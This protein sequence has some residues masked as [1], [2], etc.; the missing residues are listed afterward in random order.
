MIFRFVGRF[1]IATLVALHLCVAGAAD[2]LPATKLPIP[3]AGAACGTNPN[4]TVPFATS[5]QASTAV[6]G[7]TL[8]VN[9]LSNKAILN[10][11]DFNIGK[12]GSVIFKQPGV[13]SSA[14]NR[15]WQA[16]P[17]VI[18]GALKANGQIFLI[19]QNGI[20]FDKGAQVN[21]GSL[22]A[23][24]LNITDELFQQGFLSAI[25]DTSPV[26]AFDAVT[27]PDGT[28]LSGSIVV[29]DGATL[30]ADQS[31]NGRIMLFGTNVQNGG[32]ITAPDGQVVLAAGEKVYLLASQD[33]NLRGLF[34]EVANP[35]LSAPNAA[36]D[37]AGTASNL[38]LGKIIAERGNV[39]LAGLAVNQNG[40]ISATTA[41]NANGSIRLQA[42][43]APIGVEVESSVPQ[44]FSGRQ[45]GG[46]LALGK[47]SMSEVLPDLA[48][49]A[50][51]DSNAVFN[52]SAVTLAGKSILHQGKILAPGG[53]V[54]LT[55]EDASGAP[56]RVFLAEGSSIDVAGTVSTLL[57]M[58]RNQL[59]VELRGDELKDFPVQRDGFLR[60]QKVTIDVSRGTTVAD[61]SKQVAAIQRG[62]GEKSAQGGNI[63]LSS[64]NEVLIQPGAILDVSGGEVT[65]QSGFLNT[66]KLVD[67]DGRIFD[68]ASASPLRTY[69]GLA[70]T[71]VDEHPVWR[72]NRSFGA[73][74]TSQFIPSFVE[75]QNA[76]QISVSGKVL[77]LEGLMRGTATAGVN[78][79]E[80][81]KRPLAGKLAVGTVSPN[82]GSPSMIDLAV[83]KPLSPLSFDTPP[84]NDGALVLTVDQMLGGGL[85]RFAFFADGPI[86]IPGDV[87]LNLS[88]GGELAFTGRG[89]ELQGSIVAPSGS[90]SL[91]SEERGGASGDLR[92]GSSSLLSARGQWVND[93]PLLQLQP[94][95][96]PALINGGS[97]NLRSTANLLIGDVDGNGVVR[98]AV[99]DVS[100]G[101]WLTDK[102]QLRKGNGGSVALEVLQTLDVTKDPGTLQLAAVIRALAPGKG[103]RLSISA[104]EVLLRNGAP[105]TGAQGSYLAP[106][107]IA[108][109]TQFVAPSWM[110][111]SLGFSSYELTDTRRGLSIADD[112]QINLAAP[113][114]LL[115]STFT[116]RETGSD[117]YSFSSEASDAQVRTPTNLGLRHNFVARPDAVD[118]T[119]RV[120]S[121]SSI[122][123]DP[124]ANVSITSSTAI[125]ADGTIRAPAGNISLTLPE[126]PTALYG[127]NPRG[128][129]W[130]G[131]NASLSA[132]G[133]FVPGASALGLREGQVL[134]G[135][136][137]SLAANEGYIVMAPGSR[138][139]V[140]GASAQIDVPR[141][142]SSPL[143][144][145]SNAGSVTLVAEQGMVLGGELRAR[146]GTDQAVGGSLTA[147]VTD[148]VRDRSGNPDLL[149]QFPTGDRSIR[150]AQQTAAFPAEFEFGGDIDLKAENGIATFSVEQTSLGAFAS[151]VLRADN[152]VQLAEG[153]A[154]KQARS[155]QLD[156]PNLDVPGGGATLSAPY[157]ALGHSVS[158]R[159]DAQIFQLTP[160]AS[161]GIGSLSVQADVID[162]LGYIGL[163]GVGDTLLAASQAIRT[164]GVRS[165][166]LDPALA[167]ETGQDILSGALL[168]AGNITL[169]SP[170]TYPTSASSYR[171]KT[172]TG[173]ITI[174]S[175]SSTNGH[176]GILSAGG[177]LSVE[178]PTIL[179]SGVLRAPLG[180]IK[181]VAGASL[182]LAPGSVTSTAMTPAV[183]AVPYG[184]TQN[185]L[186]WLLDLGG[187]SRPLPAPPQASITLNAPQ[188]DIQAG[189]V[190]D[191]SGGGDLYAYEFVSG[192][193]GS[194]DTLAAVGQQ[195]AVLPALGAGYAPYDPHY[196][197]G[198]TV[199]P[200]DA[201][202]ISGAGGLPSGTYTM[203]PARYA[204]L[205]GAYLVTP[206]SGFQDLQPGDVVR[207]LD[208]V[209]IVAG[210]RA[211]LGTD[212]VDSRYSG[213]TVEPGTAARM[214]SE[215]RDSFANAFFATQALRRDTQVPRLPRDAGSLSA[216]ATQSLGFAGDFL[217]TPAKDGRGAVVDVSAQNLK[218]VST[219]T[220][221]PSFVQL[222]V[223]D[224]SNLKAESLLIGGTRSRSDA[225]TQ[226]AI[227]TQQ[228]VVDTAGNALSAPEIM[229]AATDTITVKSGSVVDG[230]G[231]LA[232]DA[233]LS[234]VD[235]SGGTAGALV[236]VSAAALPVALQRPANVDRTRG[237]IVIDSGAELRAARSVLLDAS[238]DTRA[239]GTISLGQGGELSVGAGRISLG[240]VG[241]VADGLI[242]NNDQL[243]GLTGLRSLNLRSYSS[244]DFWGTAQLAGRAVTLDAAALLGLDN[245]GKAATVTAD[246]LR[247]QNSNASL[248][249]S[250][251]GG[252]GA[253][254]VSADQLVLGAGAKTIRGFA[255]SDFTG[256]SE[257]LLE[258][259]GALN[260]DGALKLAAHRIA[261][262]SAAV[263]EVRSAGALEIAGLARPEDFVATQ[264]LGAHLSFAGAS[265]L[266]GG[267]IDA[268]AG[269]VELRAEGANGSLR[270]A[271]GSVTSAPGAT[272]NF[273]GLVLPLPAGKVRLVSAQGDVE[274]QQGALVDVSARGEAGAAGSISVSAIGGNALLAG[275]LLATAQSPELSGSFSLDAKSIGATSAGPQDLGDLISLLNLGQFDL[276]RTFRVRAGDLTLPAGEGREMRARSVRVVADAGRIDIQGVIRANAPKGGAIEIAARDQIKLHAGAV[277]DASAA[278]ALDRAGRISLATTSGDLALDSGS[279]VALGSSVAPGELWLRAPRTRSIGAALDNEVAVSNIAADL[280]GAGRVVVEGFR[281]YN[282]VDATDLATWQ[283]DTD[284]YMQNANTIQARLA[285]GA[286]PVVLRPGVEIRSNNDFALGSSWDLSTWRY[287]GQP[288]ALT[289]R[290]AGNLDLGVPTPP[291][292]QNVRAAFQ[293]ILNDGFDSSAAN[294]QLL[295]NESWS[296]RL[297]AGADLASAD[298]LALLPL[299]QLSESAGNVTLAASSVVRTGTGSIDIAAGRDF[300]LGRSAGGVNQSSAAVYTAGR[301]TTNND[302]PVL[303][304]DP[305][306]PADDFRVPTNANYPT[307]GGNV[308]IRAQQ[309]VQ[310]AISHQ[311]ITNWLQRRGRTNAQTGDILT[312]FNTSWHI[313]F[314]RFQ[315]NVGA[316]GGGNVNVEAGRDVIN[317]S[318]VAPTTGRLGGT[319]EPQ[320]DGSVRM[321]VLPE[322]LVVLG[323]GDIRIDAARDI[324]SG[325]FFVARGQANLTAGGS[326]R[327]GRT[328]A[329]TGG[330]SDSPIHTIL[331]LADGDF[332]LHAA[333]DIKLETVLNPTAIPQASTGTQPL[334]PNERTYFFTYSDQAAVSATALTGGV[335][336]NNDVP[337]LIDSALPR[338]FGNTGR[339][340]IRASSEEERS[341]T[342]YAPT[343]AA[344]AIEGTITQRLGETYLFPAA[345]GNLS[346]LAG[347]NVDLAAPGVAIKMLDV[348]LGLLPSPLS[349]PTAGVPTFNPIAA[350]LT[351]LGPQSHADPLLHSGDSQLNRI[352]ALEGD[353]AGAFMLPK[354]TRFKAGRDITNI[355]FVGQ[356]LEAS[357]V[358]ALNAGRDVVFP[359]VRDASGAISASGEIRLGGPGRLELTAGRNVDLGSA[360][361]V[362]TQGRRDNQAL[363]EEGASITIA[364]GLSEVTDYTAFIRKFIDP[365]AQLGPNDYQDAKK[366]AAASR[367]ILKVA[368]EDPVE[369]QRIAGLSDEDALQSLRTSWLAASG[370]RVLSYMRRLTG[371]ETLAEAQALEQ[372]KGL[373]PDQ[374]RPVVLDVFYDQL[375][376]GGRGF[377]KVGESA[378]A[379]GFDAV[380]TLFPGSAYQGDVTLLLSQIKTQAGGDINLLVPGGKVNA[381]QT[382]A[383]GEFGGGKSAANLGL[384]VEDTGNIRSFTD[385]NFDVNESRVVTL[386]GG[387][388]LMWSSRGDIDAGRGA[389]T[390]AAAPAPVLLIDNN[391]GTTFRVTAFSGSGIRSFLLE[392]G[393][394]P[395]DVDLIAPTGEVNAG[396][397]GIGAA[398]N[399]NIAALRVVG[400]DNIQVGGLSTGVPISDV[401]GIGAG[402]TGLSNVASEASKAAEQ[403]TQ[404]AV[405]TSGQADAL[406]KTVMPSFITVE[407]LDDDADE[408]ERK[409]RRAAPK[410]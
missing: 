367:E 74:S 304:G 313:D 102:G 301:A 306:D 294:A 260:V 63:T 93:S 198:S 205:P 41:V 239:L 162:L 264:G 70:G 259:R 275:N 185:G 130:L 327:E 315:Q 363:P 247:F 88:P 321:R 110:F 58:S 386:R 398:G 144:V 404:Q 227:G 69:V 361:G 36:S 65:Y 82:I 115:D 399:L 369:Q 68:I 199:R 211:V 94:G 379:R 53:K 156:A 242:L 172:D 285:T 149:S 324:A 134:P 297:V 57:P 18:Q 186:E 20:L 116:S 201:I 125:F 50:T 161:P 47:D 160:V 282:A 226:I 106:A 179:Q 341:F 122:T 406:S 390:A 213:F 152:S 3:C 286:T 26:S 89:I 397:A 393:I 56:T 37:S 24:T 238:S 344:Y 373:A 19:N 232:A 368:T 364:A 354:A 43:D 234:L 342:T 131:A 34:V 129:I 280:R 83:S 103:G 22:V 55:A 10:W 197:F 252:T 349:I 60:G 9:Q 104:G 77:R 98:P 351:S 146:A 300:V 329:D 139:D 191:L 250:T 158:A 73:D 330:N 127:Y 302:F 372:F 353:I 12:D 400:A 14:L 90:I 249:L 243:A 159:E 72:T 86:N 208:G 128:A 64:V 165:P 289:L 207:R 142:A 290:A 220:E 244:I 42:G 268:P 332:K 374:Q 331:A 119:V 358:T 168:A 246:Q 181:L 320:P 141:Q 16:D 305:N 54:E 230:T 254:V 81:G 403:A 78:Q 269:V 263:N 105:V 274:L 224:L 120:G 99:L 322:N 296:Y 202:Q 271:A 95:S 270:L 46:A 59:E 253:L 378:Y 339:D 381:G 333:G 138:I 192:P 318:V 75:G 380:N 347:E 383:T 343:L 155:L 11:Q 15:I 48:S 216:F 319:A 170:Q 4:L 133:V 44:R 175:A 323:G 210:R 214:R 370:K 178:A 345:R 32:L 176:Q 401:G 311:L 272:R 79:R 317:L 233:Q 23:S 337:R 163:R 241:Q 336:F 219:R 229:L 357:D 396:D 360:T 117:I 107:D 225:G 283:A 137:V 111:G 209:P 147:R 17:S 265:V 190:V 340:G 136:S 13:S 187:V 223:A 377:A 408:D 292:S 382:T 28:V 166:S 316:L 350:R 71:H 257:I 5:G 1:E 118:F 189:A 40:R 62:V 91:S 314:S 80:G 235:P 66:T 121:R 303:L 114:L 248:D 150:V 388:I 359:I 203:L 385:G 184:R 309:D 39:S 366:L 255:Q 6:N 312:N 100:G 375:R 188:T 140:S 212:F 215:Y 405:S 123:A 326:I 135:G 384:I 35:S 256:T 355:T 325:V 276:S 67:R 356:N 261:G 410:K 328:A 237:S 148:S 262:V 240:E 281:V 126:V 143:Q 277:L 395:G 31:K 228:L 371:N 153:V 394:T 151:T 180:T 338:G 389:K 335:L 182:T 145:G 298:A 113:Y 222:T 409:R 109:S 30:S 278:Q 245:A 221:D 194:A 266:Q 251:T 97:I 183:G 273:D 287:G 365:S 217:T 112:T 33:P 402:L 27:G 348:S 7:A 346:L 51:I 307:A 218:I 200:G 177:E 87:A 157:V 291:A 171:I 299:S 85:S 124:L 387:S 310:G 29:N 2:P 169:R 174:D 193:G 206:T 392:E 76:G 231:S 293:A 196:S 352:V 236:R 101:G 84:L 288:G 45:R 108:T 96:G 52:P 173:A 8:T 195:F 279:I 167:N 391:G 204:L 49:K 284:A 21:V 154:L 132:A 38:P 164:R 376:E 267:N 25:T 258:G 407:V 362:I 61:V 308:S 334:S 92:I 295:S